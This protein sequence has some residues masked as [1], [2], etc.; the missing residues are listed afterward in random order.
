M[1]KK[2]IIPIVVVILAIVVIAGYLISTN[3]VG[4]N[5]TSIKS[6]N[7]TGY[8]FS[9][10]GNWTVSNTS[11]SDSTDEIIRVSKGQS[12]TYIQIQKSSLGSMTAE[13]VL[14]AQEEIPDNY[15][16]VSS[17]NLTVDGNTAYQT[18]YTL[19]SNGKTYKQSSIK[20]VKN[21]DIYYITFEALEST[22][23]QDKAT[24]DSILNSFKIQ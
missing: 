3:Y 21:G 23:D 2:L 15:Q 13:Q 11:V 18:I 7:G 17:N 22:F 1:N 5:G 14:N 8:S 20:F 16:K 24:L 19:N 10:P 12:D 9:Y 4:S 6:F